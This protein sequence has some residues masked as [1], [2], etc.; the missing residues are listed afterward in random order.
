MRKIRYLLIIPLLLIIFSCKKN[1]SLTKQVN[2]LKEVGNLKDSLE[3]DKWTLYSNDKLVKKGSYLGGLKTGIW[4]YHY[5]DSIYKLEWDTY[6]YDS[7]NI[8]FNYPKNWVVKKNH[9]Y[10]FLAQP[11]PKIPSNYC[12]ALRYNKI[13]KKLDLNSYLKI[14]YE[15]I[16]NDKEEITS[17]YELK[18]VTFSSDE[19]IYYGNFSSVLNNTKYLTYVFYMDYKDFI[20][21]FSYKTLRNNNHDIVNK[22]IFGDIIYSIFINN[23]KIFHDKYIKEIDL[24]NLVDLAN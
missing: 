5:N 19:I 24:V 16:K 23:K 17:K 14:L 20:Y 1:K 15:Q 13:N 3:S 2:V 21:D 9:E 4:E 22:A 8:M 11:I 12:V 10:L 7:L 6:K 18:K